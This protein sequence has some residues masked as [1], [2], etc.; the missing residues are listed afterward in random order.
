MGYI[1]ICENCTCANIKFIE[2]KGELLTKITGKMCNG[3]LALQ[4][5]DDRDDMRITL[6]DAANVYKGM[7]KRI[8]LPGNQNFLY[9]FDFNDSER[10]S[11]RKLLKLQ[12][13]NC[14][15][16]VANMLICFDFSN[17]K[18]V[19][20]LLPN[21]AELKKWAEALNINTYEA[22][23]KVGEVTAVRNVRDL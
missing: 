8:L 19:C 6:S 4:I 13:Q 5:F 15:S 7:I 16:G 17:H 18:G 20:Y 10:N 3:T 22:L 9:H 11:K 2:Q 23:N 1:L 12:V 14:E 21:A